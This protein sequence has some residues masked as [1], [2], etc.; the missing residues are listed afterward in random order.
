HTYDQEEIDNALYSAFYNRD[1]KKIETNFLHFIEKPHVFNKHYIKCI[2]A[3]LRY[4]T[5]NIKPLATEESLTSPLF[6]YALVCGKYTLLLNEKCDR[7]YFVCEPALSSAISENFL[8][9]K[10]KSSPFIIV[11]VDEAEI[12]TRETSD[13]FNV[14]SEKPVIVCSIPGACVKELT[15]DCWNEVVRK[16]LPKKEADFLSYSYLNYHHFQLENIQRHY[17]LSDSLL[18]FAKSGEYA[19]ISHRYINSFPSSLRKTIIKNLKEA[20]KEKKNFIINS[21][22]ISFPNFVQIDYY[23]SSTRIHFD[24]VY[25]KFNIYNTSAIISHNDSAGSKK[26]FEALLAYQT[27]VKS[28]LTATQTDYTFE[29]MLLLCGK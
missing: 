6:P 29:S 20:Y 27:G 3:A 21:D 16:D 24:S 10:K 5:I 19:S 2:W 25:R 28:L 15:Y 17:I 26:F 9:L 11:C 12:M 8:S 4:G 22:K 1:E 13:C 14:A 23:P 18:E 7:A